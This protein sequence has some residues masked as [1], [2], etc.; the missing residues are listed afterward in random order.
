M[1]INNTATIH[2]YP[3]DV[4]DKLEFSTIK[5]WLIESAISNMG[6]ALAEN[7][8]PYYNIEIIREK[9]AETKFF[10]ETI[11][12]QLHFPTQNYH[13]ISS[14]VQKLSILHNYLTIDEIVQIREISIT[15]NEISV[16]MKKH[17]SE[18][19]MLALK[20]IFLT[21]NI[22]P[23][24]NAEI[25]K[26][27]DENNDIKPNASKDLM[28]IR[29]RLADKKHDLENTFKRVVKTYK[30]RG[31]F[32]AEIEESVRNGRRV[33]AV[34]SEQKRNLKGIVHDLSST[35]STTFIEPEETV[36]LNNDI[37]ELE[38]EEKKEIIK[39][40]KLLTDELRPFSEDLMSYQ[41][42]LGI[43]DF[44]LSKAK[45]AQKLN[46]TTPEIQEKPIFDF[47][48][49]YHPIL[50]LQN[51]KNEVIP[52][53]LQLH[54]QNN[55]LV[56]SG[57]NAGG[58]S[59]TMK[60]VG[61]LQIMAQSGMA[62]PV[63][64][65]TKIG[66]FKTFFTDIGDQQSMQDELSTYSSRL[67]NYKFFLQHTHEST[68]LLIDEFGTGTDP[69]IGGAIAQAVLHDLQKKKCFAV[70]TTHYANIKSYAHNN[71]GLVNG[72]M[73]FDKQKLA[74]TY[75]LQI[76]KPGSSYAFEIT[77]KIGLPKSI[78]HHAKTLTE[79]KL[80]DVD[81]LLADIQYQ[82][83]N[84]KKKQEEIDKKEKH[85]DDWIKKYAGLNKDFELQNKKMKLEFRQYKAEMQSKQRDEW[86]K[87]LGEIKT[88]IK[89]EKK[90]EAQ[91]QIIKKELE[92][93]IVEE[94]Q[95]KDEIKTIKESLNYNIIQRKPVK[96]D[97][98]LIN[99]QTEIGIVENIGNK[100]ALVFFG[101]IKTKVNINLLQVVEKPKTTTLKKH[102]QFD[103]LSK[104]VAFKNELDIRGNNKQ[105]AL[106]ILETF[107]DEA[108]MLNINSLRI[109]HGK[110]NGILKIV[111]RE[112]LKEYKKNIES[113][114][115][116]NQQNGGDGVSI[117]TLK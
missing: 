9:L 79:G 70:I 11:Q 3:D 96:G 87:M 53:D 117:I 14:T 29:R 40:L 71:K 25:N 84:I 59:V 83:E 54:H 8:L 18:I 101:N 39:I 76:G 13:E 98:V 31:N 85:L 62:I 26:I 43:C 80:K 104:S 116:E 24:I 21:V 99:D 42:A 35:G 108:L 110:G 57:P 32:L 36:H 75:R 47:V 95:T 115:Y 20:N 52:F 30:E 100:E 67:N 102:V 45:L 91:E 19:N 4:L 17:V 37:L 66:I 46:A 103:V 12:K 94:K 97:S 92:K 69:V 113:V 106:E 93:I 74:P 61:L 50:L 89:E 2:F 55:I 6:K 78:I 82:Q 56:I 64:P 72:S 27:L 51:K 7:I 38:L 60:A 114:Q 107:I 1:D 65:N 10:Q 77:E 86:N 22:Q 73:I 81:K 49:A 63:A 28:M 111:L 34:L 105:E 5:N 44:A 109:I 23:K 90:V 68:L 112:K 16:F 48:Q 15:I 88:K 41:Q 33:L 58:K